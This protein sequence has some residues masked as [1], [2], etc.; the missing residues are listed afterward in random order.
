MGIT[1]KKYI[2]LN[3]NAMFEIAD[4]RFFLF[5]NKKFVPTGVLR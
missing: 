2:T 5:I 1:P 4:G 3:M